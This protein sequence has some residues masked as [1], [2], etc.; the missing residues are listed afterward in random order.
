MTQ[1]RKMST[2][3]KVLL[4]V[5]AVLMAAAIGVVIM[6]L[7]RYD[8][9]KENPYLAFENAGTST[10]SE[11]SAEMLGITEGYVHQVTTEE[12]E[13]LEAQQGVVNVAFLGLDSSDERDAQQMGARSDMV[14]IASINLDTGK[15]EVIS[16]PRDTYTD[17]YKFDYDTGEVSG[18]YKDKIT[19]GYPA[20]GGTRY[21]GAQSVMMAA[22]NLLSCDGQYY[23]PLDLYFTIDM[24]GIYEICDALGGVEVTLD[25]DM[26]YLADV[27]GH[28]TNR[29]IGREGE[30]V[31]LDGEAAYSFVRARKD[32]PGG[33]LGRTSNQQIFMMGVLEKIKE[34]G[35][36]ASATALYDEFL[37]FATTNISIDQALA[38]ASVIDK[39]EFDDITFQTLDGE[40]DYVSGTGDVVMIDEAAMMETVQEMFYVTGVTG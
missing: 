27:G 18:S 40:L 36:V 2:P 22:S 11:Y 3:V 33:D 16:I 38:F 12:G 34:M 20:G 14:M 24:D 25:Y 19:H 39:I 13:V 15:T 30:T 1:K 7:S 37:T 31:L 23:I 10:G 29:L 32:I 6:I 26:Y 8:D 4:A 5:L 21:Y 28:N 17:V 9:L 35:A